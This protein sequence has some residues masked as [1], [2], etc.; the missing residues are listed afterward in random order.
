[1]EVG[2]EPTHWPAMV[3]LDSQVTKTKDY[4]DE[5]DAFTKALSQDAGVEVSD[6]GQGAWPQRFILDG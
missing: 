6:V 2:L 1:M 3:G 4:Y 5:T